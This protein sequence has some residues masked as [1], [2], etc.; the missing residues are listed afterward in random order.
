[1]RTNDRFSVVETLTA[2]P[3]RIVLRANPRHA[4]PA[5]AVDTRRLDAGDNRQHPWPPSHA[6]RTTPRTP[7]GAH[8]ACVQ[9]PAGEILVR[10]DTSRADE[11]I[12]TLR[13]RRKQRRSEILAVS[14]AVA[15]VVALVVAVLLG[16]LAAVIA[17][18]LTFPLAYRAVALG[19]AALDRDE[20]GRERPTAPGADATPA[21]PVRARDAEPFQRERS[22]NGY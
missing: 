10:A 1:M 9:R 5:P 4:W 11:L 16:V 15:V 2:G 19:P 7:R 14:A 20:R 22:V 8:S 21:S 18:A 13:S 17:G 6:Q 3:R 12:A